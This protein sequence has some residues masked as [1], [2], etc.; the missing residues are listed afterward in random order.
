MTNMM[1]KILGA[2]ILVVLIGAIIFAKSKGVS[3]LSW[4]MHKAISQKNG[5][6]IGGFDAVNY[7]ENKNAIKGTA[8][9]TENWKEVNWQ[10]IS[11]ENLDKFKSN[12]EQYEPQFGGWCAFA[13]SKGFTA[14]PDPNAWLSKNGKLYL[15]AD[16]GVKKQWEEQLPKVLETCTK[17][18]TY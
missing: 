13:V 7:V 1:L 9:F 6:A 12:P 10:F 15:F 17:K 14:T 18:W 8:A 4:K 3:P 5:I 16:E 2:I 11:Q